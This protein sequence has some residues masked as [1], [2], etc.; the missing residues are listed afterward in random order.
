[1]P[2]V[3]TLPF[4]KPHFHDNAG[5]PATGYKLY[6][7]DSTTHDAIPLY[8]DPAGTIEY[9]NPV[10]LNSR[11]EP[12]GTSIYLDNDKVYKLILK[13]ESDVEVW[14]I[15]AVK[16]VGG[17]G[18]V[19]V[20]LIPLPGHTVL[21]NATDNAGNSYAV[22]IVDVITDTTDENLVVSVGAVN[23]ALDEYLPNSGNN[24]Y[25]GNLTISGEVNASNIKVNGVDID[26]I[27][28]AKDGHTART[29]VGNIDDTA[30]MVEDIAIVNT[31]ASGSANEIPS[32]QAVKSYVDT[33]V[34]EL[35]AEIA[36]NSP[37]GKI[38]VSATDVADYAEVKIIGGNRASITKVIEDNQE[39]LKID[40]NLDDLKDISYVFQAYGQNSAF[41]TIVND[42]IYAGYATDP[43]NFNSAFDPLT[44]RF[45]CAE[46]GYYHFDASA[47]INQAGT[48]S[49]ST[50]KFY[51]NHFDSTGVLVTS[52]EGFATVPA[53]PTNHANF[54]L[55]V[56]GNFHLAVND[57]VGVVF[58]LA[59][60]GDLYVN[61]V[62]FGGFSLDS[63]TGALGAGTPNRL[64]AYDADGKLNPAQLLVYDN[65][66]NLLLGYNNSIGSG[67]AEAVAIGRSN[68]VTSQDSVAIGHSNNLSAGSSHGIA[69]AFG[70]QNTVNAPECMGVGI[71]NNVGL[72]TAGET[73]ALGLENTINGSEVVGVGHNNNVNGAAST[74]LGKSITGTSLMGT[75]V[76]GQNVDATGASNKTLIGHNLTAS[77]LPAPTSMAIGSNNDYITLFGKYVDQFG[78]IG[79]RG[80]FIGFDVD[81]KLKVTNE[82][83]DVK[84]I[85]DA[86]VTP[87]EGQLAW[88]ALDKTLNVGL[89]GGSTLQLGQEELVYA[90]NQTGGTISNG[91]VV[92]VSGSQGQRVVVSLA[93]AV[94]TPTNQVFIAV[95]TQAINNNQ[96]GYLT[97]FGIVRE[98]NTA[99]YLEGDI[100][101]VSSTAGKMTSLQPSKP[102]SQ[103]AVAIVTRA[104]AVQGTI[105]VSPY[106]VPRLGQLT[107]V[108]VAGA[109]DGQALVY[110]ASTGLWIP[111]IASGG[112]SDGK[113]KVTAGDTAD[114]A[115]TKFTSSD[116]SVDITVNAGSIDLTV[117]LCNDVSK[118]STASTSTSSSGI[119]QFNS[120]EF[121]NWTVNGGSIIAPIAGTHQINLVGKILYN[122]EVDSSLAFRGTASG[123][124]SNITN[125]KVAW[126]FA[127]FGNWNIAKDRMTVLE[128]GKIQLNVSFMLYTSN[129]TGTN[130]TMGDLSVR[131]YRSNGSLLRQYT[132]A[133]ILTG[134]A[135]QSGYYYDS[136]DHAEV[137]DVLVG[138]YFETHMTVEGNGYMQDARITGGMLSNIN[139]TVGNTSALAINHRASNG[140]LKTSYPLF[141][142]TQPYRGF[143]T[144]SFGKIYEVE[145]GDKFDVSW[146]PS[147]NITALT[148]VVMSGALM[149][150]SSVGSGS[151]DPTL[152]GLMT[153]PLIISNGSI[154]TGHT[155][156]Q[157][158]TYTSAR[159]IP[160]ARVEANFISCFTTQIG[161]FYGLRMG[162]YMPGPSGDT[163]IAQ[164]DKLTVTPSTGIITLP[165][166]YD[167][168]GAPLSTPLTLHPNIS[169]MLASVIKSNGCFFA[170]YTGIS[171][172]QPNHFGRQDNWNAPAPTNLMDQTAGYSQTG[173][174]IWMSVSN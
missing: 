37:N 113:I 77:T 165:I 88:N 3:S 149:Q 81:N 145:V 171:T 54:S 128:A 25:N 80:R 129:A 72:V 154:A 24:T 51:L 170:A 158:A 49:A 22:E 26:D 118:F 69:Y 123:Q 41:D 139:N 167:A 78:N 96:M 119:V 34:T 16:G 52:T 127:D 6:S 109:T 93:Q 102:Y 44:G 163:L 39:K 112:V 121:G 18:S 124:Y 162:I 29:L 33:E 105:M 103:I 173:Q 148:D 59:N 30:G 101:W 99:A 108:S 20:P 151:S 141:D 142:A 70:R 68:V 114:Y 152:D 164:T 169:Y 13:T 53:D 174:F 117:D 138:D 10:I 55:A 83:T 71:R 36:A 90:M 1:M 46:S 136:V 9:T 8:K 130:K 144:L 60:T 85:T 19:N 56:S 131:H 23:L 125:Q 107:D 47:L 58:N 43:V 122:T 62:A 73:I 157:G 67:V 75:V 159:V 91:D 95:A 161:T 134:L 137:V 74:V 98:V 89:A 86:G 155:V 166:L 66:R 111:G 97:R 64:A 147:S 156:D 61:K 42:E 2:T 120:L 140:S 45:T 87:V 106:N 150:S 76:V 160:A 92:Y 38:K 143:E 32:V 27:Y 40:I 28:I 168:T 172:N 12:D 110:Q 65:L 100:L 146:T 15:N 126:D 115:G 82:V 11:G 133:A 79:I 50:C 84:F 48:V 57:Y 5:S 153:Y 35:E 17:S 21:G 132:A 7:Y 14:D 4:I 94:T 135:S 31:L 63:A 116:N 104:H